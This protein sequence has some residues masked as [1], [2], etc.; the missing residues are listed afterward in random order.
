MGRLS[1]NADPWNNIP[2]FSNCCSYN[3]DDAPTS[4]TPSN[5][6]LPESG[7]N[8]PNIHFNMTD[9]PVPDPPITTKDSWGATSIQMSLSTCLGPNDLCKFV[10]LS[11]GDV[12]KEKSF[13]KGNSVNTTYYTILPV[14]RRA[15]KISP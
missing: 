1:N 15:Y 3:F 2:I 9:F 14:C 4:S 12:I 10:I 11:F 8:N 7:F 5:W 6:M 13:K